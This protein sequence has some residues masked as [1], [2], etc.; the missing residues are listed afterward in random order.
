MGFLISVALGIKHGHFKGV[1]EFFI[2]SLVLW[3]IFIIPVTGYGN[4]SSAMENHGDVNITAQDIIKE[5]VSSDQAPM[6][7][8]TASKILNL[9]AALQTVRDGTKDNHEKITSAFRESVE[10]ARREKMDQKAEHTA[11]LAFRARPD[12]KPDSDMRALLTNL[13]RNAIKQPSVEWKYHYRPLQQSGH[14]L[15]LHYASTTLAKASYL[16]FG[17]EPF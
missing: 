17:A 9:Y 1:G 15:T 16:T 12:I 10:I 2:L 6:F 11:L 5:K 3:F 4:I 7:L 8:I 13:K 14:P